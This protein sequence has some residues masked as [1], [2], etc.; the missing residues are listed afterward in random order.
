MEPKY[1]LRFGEVI[2][3]HLLIESENMTVDSKGTVCLLPGGYPPNILDRNGTLE[4]F[5]ERNAMQQEIAYCIEIM[6]LYLYTCLYMF[7]SKTNDIYKL[8]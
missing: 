2:G 3:H 8:L 4:V 5:Q 1:D 7:Q 6:N